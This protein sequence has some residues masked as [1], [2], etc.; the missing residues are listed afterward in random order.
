MHCKNDP[1]KECADEWQCP[2]GPC[3]SSSHTCAGASWKYCEED[4]D[5][6]YDSCVLQD[7][8]DPATKKVLC[9]AQC[10]KPVTCGDG[11]VQ[12]EEECD[13]KKGGC[14]ACKLDRLDLCGNGKFDSAAGEQCDDGNRAG[15]DGCSATCQY[16]ESACPGSCFLAFA[17]SPES[18]YAGDTCSPDIANECPGGSCVMR[19]QC[20]EDCMFGFC[21]NGTVDPGEQCDDGRHCLHDPSKTCSTNVDCSAGSCTGADPVNRVAGTCAD[22]PAR[23]CMTGDDCQSLC[24]PVGE[25]G[26]SPACQ[27][28]VTPKGK[29]AQASATIILCQEEVSRIG[30]DQVDEWQETLLDPEGNPFLGWQNGGWWSWYWDFHQW[31][32]ISRFGWGGYWTWYG[33]GMFGTNCREEPQKCLAQF[34]NS[35]GYLVQAVTGSFGWVAQHRTMPDRMALMPFEPAGIVS[36]PACQELRP[37]LASVVEIPAQSPVNLPPYEPSALVRNIEKFLCEEGGF[38]RRNFPFLCL[39]DTSG[40]LGGIAPSPEY[41]SAVRL[42]EMV[43]GNTLAIGYRSGERVLSDYLS[44]AV[45]TLAQ[46]LETAVRLFTNLERVEFATEE[47]PLNDDVLCTP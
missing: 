22:E 46:S 12:A 24:L 45:Q 5:C 9:T 18:V 17:C 15:N 35:A 3:D 8:I 33:G 37:A 2:I 26:C 27:H 25:D 11:H 29:L 16:E 14:I 34:P 32:L 20:A 1:T 4:V 36:Y 31:N 41:A 7:E 39:S 6:G 21:G 13:H 38:P 28:E 42:R 43:L 30:A 44:E 23:S 40:L 47:C 19:T 10:T